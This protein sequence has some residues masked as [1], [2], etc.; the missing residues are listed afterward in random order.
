[1]FQELTSLTCCGDANPSQSGGTSHNIISIRI[2]E[3]QNRL[4]ACDL[5]LL[6][7][8]V[9]SLSRSTCTSIVVT[10][11]TDL[12][13]ST[14]YPVL[15][16]LSDM[17]YFCFSSRS[18]TKE[19]FLINILCTILLFIICF[20]F[21]IITI[22]GGQRL[23]ADPLYINELDTINSLLHHKNMSGEVWISDP[24]LL[25]LH[26]ERTKLRVSAVD[27]K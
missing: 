24:L 12:C 8:P 14:V 18:L 7:A 19:L 15:L 13:R 11:V 1:M 6:L 5:L 2:S 21:F 16:R 10:Y 9:I 4:L 17:G 22:L 23:D 25:S 3:Y 20:L 27:P 26:N